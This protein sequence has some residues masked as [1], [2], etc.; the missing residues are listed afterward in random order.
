[1]SGA[2]KLFKAVEASGG[3][4]GGVASGDG[5]IDNVFSNQGHANPSNSTLRIYNTIDLTGSNEGMIW[6]KNRTRSD[7]HGYIADTIRGPAKFLYLGSNQAEETE[8]AQDGVNSFNNDGFTL[9][10]AG[11]DVNGFAESMAHWVFKKANNF[12]HVS[13]I[14]V[15]T[16]S[17]VSVDLSALGTVGMVWAKSIDT[18]SKF[19]V[20]H[21]SFTTINY[22]VTVANV[23]GQNI[24]LIDG[25]NNPVLNL[26]RGN[27]YIFNQSDTTNS[28]HPFAFKNSTDDSYTNGVSAT[29]TAGSNRIITFVVPFDAP[30][31]LK[32]YCTVHGNNMGNTIS[33]T[34]HFMLMDANSVEQTASDPKLNVS[35][36]TA[37]VTPGSSSHYGNYIIY[38]WADNSSI[39]NAD[40]LVMCGDYT[41]VATSLTQEIDLGF[42][43]EFLFVKAYQTSTNYSVFDR[44][45]GWSFSDVVGNQSSRAINA[46]AQASEYNVTNAIKPTSR[47]FQVPASAEVNF[48]AENYKYIYMAIRRGPMRSTTSPTN[49][50]V[51][52]SLI[53]GSVNQIG[54][55]AT[56]RPDFAF[57]GPTTGTLSSMPV[58][59]TQRSLPGVIYPYLA[60]AFQ[61]TAGV[62]YDKPGHFG[63]A[64]LSGYGFTEPN[65]AITGIDRVV[66]AFQNQRG[67]F[68]VCNYFTQSNYLTPRHN[69]NAVP[70]LVIFKCLSASANWGVIGSALGSGNHLKLNSNT[71]IASGSGVSL[72][73]STFLYTNGD[74]FGGKTNSSY[75]ALLFASQSGVS[76]IGTFI[77]TTGSDTSVSCPG[78]SSFPR[79]LVVKKIS[80]SGDWQW[81]SSSNGGGDYY[82]VLNNIATQVTNE[83]NFD[84]VTG[85][86]TAKSAISSGTYLF[87][88]FA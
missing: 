33:V 42:E 3:G 45:R 11:T 65:S 7:Q 60:D 31:N 34:N 5:L 9:G 18:V 62:N 4:G 35:G 56:A 88:A 82:K 49:V 53:S 12:F 15:P 71:A 83:N 47:G 38:A 21:R 78:F 74:D 22:A 51:T 52:N 69:L 17:P 55:S 72:P 70:E 66:N 61:N 81:Y 32:Y 64:Y 43:P 23:G 27:T 77:H 54:A 16:A 25:V 10:H 58:R 8:P 75:M 63:S 46:E 76:K 79:F 19:M 68:D 2:K 84:Y 26:K 48:S 57:S 67:V 41:G 14:S 6:I 24:F 20:W 29:G 85:G 37:T 73:T 28:N 80:S 87:I 50:L 59:I 36:T 30:A 86:F 39:N 44:Q 13:S 1:M 40:R